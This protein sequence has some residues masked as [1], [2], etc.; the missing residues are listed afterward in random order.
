M[1]LQRTQWLATTLYHDQML[2]FF[3]SC[4]NETLQ[5]ALS[6]LQTWR[7]CTLARAPKVPACHCC[8]QRSRAKSKAPNQRPTIITKSFVLTSSKKTL[9]QCGFH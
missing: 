6:R 2:C 8:G 1:L 5:N 3:E 4:S 7:V 9:R